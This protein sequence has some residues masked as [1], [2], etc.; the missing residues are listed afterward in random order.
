MVG[1]VRGD[2]GL[3]MAFRGRHPQVNLGSFRRQR[4][5]PEVPGFL[6]CE[7]LYRLGTPTRPPA[8]L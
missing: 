2:E 1:P 4:G 5:R 7:A 3:N 8:A 6:P